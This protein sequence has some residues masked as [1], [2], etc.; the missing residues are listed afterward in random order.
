MTSTL[1]P[2]NVQKT[3]VWSVG[4]PGFPI[5]A[6]EPSRSSAFEERPGHGADP[7]FL[8]GDDVAGGFCLAGL[9]R[10]CADPVSL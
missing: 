7:E 8:F 2:D 3:G 5:V 6:A 10:F 4:Q 1:S 9:T